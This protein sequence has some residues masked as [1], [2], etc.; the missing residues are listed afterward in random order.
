MGG[1]ECSHVRIKGWKAGRDG[2]LLEMCWIR[3]TVCLLVEGKPEL[4]ALSRKVTLI[5]NKITQDTR[6]T[7]NGTKEAYCSVLEEQETAL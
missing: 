5:T 6:T 4:S 3:I 1:D 2:F 7:K